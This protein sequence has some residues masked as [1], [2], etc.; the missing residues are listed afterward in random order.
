MVEAIVT[1]KV[2]GLVT[3]S[4]HLDLTDDGDGGVY[5]RK[6]GDHWGGTWKIAPHFVPVQQRTDGVAHHMARQRY[7]R[8]DSS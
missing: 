1:E 2:R 5:D 4:G 8:P 7:Q 6:F 3:P